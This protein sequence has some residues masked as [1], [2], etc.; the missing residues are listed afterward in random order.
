MLS[1]LRQSF[2]G[3][4]WQMGELFYFWGCCFGGKGK[5]KGDFGGGPRAA[6]KTILFYLFLFSFST[7]MIYIGT[8][9]SKRIF[10]FLIF[11]VFSCDV[12]RFILSGR[13]TKLQPYLHFFLKIAKL[14]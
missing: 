6:S 2:A 4:K 13:D 3:G 12:G 9:T 5:E 10:S 8:R 11:V 7:I 1:A 14:S